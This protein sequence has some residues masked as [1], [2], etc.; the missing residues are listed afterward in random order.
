[1]AG[2]IL[3]NYSDGHQTL[4]S[5]VAVRNW[6][7]RRR[8]VRM[9]KALLLLMLMLSLKPAVRTAWANADCAFYLWSKMS[10]NPIVEHRHLG[11]TRCGG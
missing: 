9:E 5:M 4:S 7:V 2:P 10:G 3:A 8:L 1:M 6:I 11:I